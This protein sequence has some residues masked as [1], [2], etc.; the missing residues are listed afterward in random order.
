MKKLNECIFT[1]LMTSAVFA[2]GEV[3]S[4]RISP[5]LFHGQKVQQ[6]VVARQEKM[7]EIVAQREGKNKLIEK[8][9]Q[10][11]ESVEKEA[12]FQQ[13]KVMMTEDAEKM[14]ELHRN[15]L[16]QFEGERAKIVKFIDRSEKAFQAQQEQVEKT[17]LLHKDMTEKAASSATTKAVPAELLQKTKE[18]QK[19][20]AEK[21]SV[22]EKALQLQ[23]DDLKQIDQEIAAIKALIE[24][25]QKNSS[26]RIDEQLRRL[27]AS[28]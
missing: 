26:Q 10:T 23:N 22:T 12:L 16:T 11:T 5:R 17:K 20:F 21:K 7:Q 19:A 14:M 25:E 13:L 18:K 8:I 4:P 3:P 9:R 28:S 6:E 15:R 24:T 1:V 27:S 2:S